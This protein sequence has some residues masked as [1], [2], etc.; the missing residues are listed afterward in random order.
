MYVIPPLIADPQPSIPIEPGQGTLDYPA[1]AAQAL[2]AFD[3]TAC[4]AVDDP[5]RSECATALIEVVTFVRV[6]LLGATPR[7]PTLAVVHER[8]RVDGRLQHLAVMNVSS[9]DDN[10]QRSSLGVYHNVALRALFAAIRWIRP[11][12]FG[13]PFGVPFFASGARA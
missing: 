8:N 2:A 6:H 9:R 3:P 11:D 13:A 4:N 5:P 12:G 7:C 1:M 10:R